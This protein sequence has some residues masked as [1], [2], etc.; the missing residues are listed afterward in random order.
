MLGFLCL[1]VPAP[2]AQAPAELP[3]SAACAGATTPRGCLAARRC[4]QEQ[5]QVSWS[6]CFRWLQD[7]RGA[8][9]AA[10]CLCPSPTFPSGITRFWHL[11]EVTFR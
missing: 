4:A 10:A 2:R 11:H 8:R 3:G 5:A 7:H 1:A 6:G 9:E